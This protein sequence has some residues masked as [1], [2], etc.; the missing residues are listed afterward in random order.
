[1]SRNPEAINSPDDGGRRD[2]QHPHAD[3]MS[4]ADLKKV[5]PVV[6]QRRPLRIPPRMQNHKMPSA[7][8]DAA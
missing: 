7:P 1:M 8:E 3:R 2:G 4:V 6:N 5:P